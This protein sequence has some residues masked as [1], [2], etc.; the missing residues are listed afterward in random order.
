MNTP[1]S[2]IAGVYVPSLPAGTVFDR[3]EGAATARGQTLDDRNHGPFACICKANAPWL[4]QLRLAAKTKPG[5]EEVADVCVST[6][7][8]R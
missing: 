2:S 7:G 3:R 5:K 4:L 1:N 6:R 8:G